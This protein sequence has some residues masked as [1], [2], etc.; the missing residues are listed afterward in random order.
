ML[1]CELDG[2]TLHVGDGFAR[3]IEF[4]L[5]RLRLVYLVVC[6]SARRYLV[7]SSQGLAFIALD[8]LS[9]EKTNEVDALLAELIAQRRS[10]GCS[11]VLTDYRG[12]SAFI[13]LAAFR[14]GAPGFAEALASA[15]PSRRARRELWLTRSPRVE[16][17]GSLGV[18]ATLTPAGFECTNRF[19]AWSDVGTVHIETTI[20]RRTDLLVL[21]HGRR[22]GFFDFRRFRHSLPFVPERLKEVYQAE[23]T[24]W[25]NRAGTARTPAHR[26]LAKPQRY[27][28][29]AAS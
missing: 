11:L 1:S 27:A 22:G 28:L 19:I 21:P 16:L 7:S 3:R 15:R 13:P 12:E 23:C 17:R 26:E 2:T 10:T 5:T 18:T 20:G 25:L 9:E 6:T 4:E 24:F 29:R 14:R 8:G